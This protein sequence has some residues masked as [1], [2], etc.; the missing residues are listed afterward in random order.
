MTLKEAK[1]NMKAYGIYDAIEDLRGYSDSADFDAVKEIIYR[2]LDNIPSEI[3][4]KAEKKA[5]R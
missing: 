2:V 4:T 5:S 1:Q 3:L